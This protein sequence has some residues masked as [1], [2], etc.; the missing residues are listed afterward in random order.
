[1][2]TGG[3]DPNGWG[4]FDYTIQYR[5]L[6]TGGAWTTWLTNTSSTS[7][8]FVPI[9]GHAYQ[10]RSLARDWA[11][12]VESKGTSQFDASTSATGTIYKTLF[13][14]IGNGG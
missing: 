10:L 13:P 9:Q 3:N 14:L 8:R 12:N 6:T 2:V 1:V 7:A 4:L 11:G 5:D